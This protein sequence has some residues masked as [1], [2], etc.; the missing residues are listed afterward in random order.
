MGDRLAQYLAMSGGTIAE[1]DHH[2]AHAFPPR[3]V[4]FEMFEYDKGATTR[5]IAR[6]ANK[7]AP[8]EATHY[9]TEEPDQ[10]RREIGINYIVAM[11]FHLHFGNPAWR[12]IERD[13]EAG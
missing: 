8:P 12:K 5:D 7:S 13:G 9:W 2:M 10:V 11:T 6:R 3:V 1:L 4:G